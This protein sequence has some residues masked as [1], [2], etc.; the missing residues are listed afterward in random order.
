MRATVNDDPDVCQS[1]T[2]ARC[3]KAAERID[4]MSGCEDDWGPKKR[5]FILF[6]C[7]QPHGDEGVASMHHLRNLFGHLL[8]SVFKTLAHTVTEIGVDVGCTCII[9]M[10]V[11]FTRTGL[12]KFSK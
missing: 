12:S 6:R 3:A 4:V 1:V 2:R 8:L 5:Y 7:P 11:K 10:S 9:Y